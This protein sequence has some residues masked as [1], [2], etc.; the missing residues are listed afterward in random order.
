M[1]GCHQ[2]GENLEGHGHR[3]G[4]C[5][6]CYNVHVILCPTCAMWDWGPLNTD[7]DAVAELIPPAV[8]VPAPRQQQNKLKKFL[9]K[10]SRSTPPCKTFLGRMAKVSK[11]I[12]R[13][14]A[15]K[16]ATLYGQRF[17]EY[18]CH[19]FNQFER[20][21]PTC[22][23]N[24]TAL[25]II[26]F[27]YHSAQE[28]IQC[29]TNRDSASTVRADVE[30][31]KR[32]QI[33]EVAA[34]L[35]LHQSDKIQEVFGR[36]TA[37]ELFNSHLYL[38]ALGYND[39]EFF[40]KGFKSPTLFAID[41]LDFANNS[42]DQAREI[43]EI[44]LIAYHVR[45]GA[46]T[47]NQWGAHW[48]NG[49]AATNFRPNEALSFVSTDHFKKL[50]GDVQQAGDLYDITQQINRVWAVLENENPGNQL[51]D[52]PRFP[53]DN[54]GG[55][56]LLSGVEKNYLQYLPTFDHKQNQPDLRTPC[57]TV[58]RNR[59]VA[60]LHSLIHGQDPPNRPGD[61]RPE[62]APPHGESA[63]P[64][65]K[66]ADD[67]TA[68]QAGQFIDQT[69]TRMWNEFAVDLA[70]DTN[71]A[72]IILQKV[73]NNDPDD[74]FKPKGWFPLKTVNVSWK[75]VFPEDG[76]DQADTFQTIRQ[77]YAAT[78]G[79]SPR[80]AHYM[81]WRNHKDHWLYDCFNIQTTRRP[82]FTSLAVHTILPEP[83]TN[84]GGNVLLFRR[85]TIRHRTVFT[86]G[87]KQQPRRSMLLVLDTILFGR[88]KKDGYDGQAP[89]ERLKVVEKILRRSCFLS[90]TVQAN[91]VN[92][93]PAQWQR[94]CTGIKV[95]YPM[96]DFLI[97]CHIFGGVDMA[98]DVMA[99]AGCFC[100]DPASNDPR[101]AVFSPNLH[102]P[103]S[104]IDEY[105]ND[106]T[107][108]DQH[109]QLLVYDPWISN[110][111]YTMPPNFP[112]PVRPKWWFKIIHS[113]RAE[114]LEDFE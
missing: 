12:K 59:V 71:V 28:R 52:H 46:R 10:F 17:S 53:D 50:F 94:S 29:R 103:R 70:F 38:K 35:L 93:L 96:P 106:I 102:L 108:F 67:W 42:A 77:H 24:K 3:T 22:K 75:D 91:I 11:Y 89:G 13:Q 76:F 80:P 84:Y 113:D 69:I 36:N 65:N 86:F 33:R 31:L 34:E 79:T 39:I 45:V 56:D 109:M 105:R 2:C 1:P 112:A 14:L 78:E 43:L 82:V 64:E 85:N 40:L 81:D 20:L 30:Y 27:M 51:P 54:V 41:L 95:G 100:Y 26:I 15:T 21:Y 47:Q 7:H 104:K 92:N 58:I 62:P 72:K 44:S 48:S 37:E 74:Q 23:Y 114:D 9:A 57:E 19:V 111:I 6:I 98:R 18:A 107:T 5:S 83:N 90:G 60:K 49:G 61:Y 32:W 8:V 63:E 101:K 55:N 66:P 97:E 4:K 68:L 87:D 16:R 99:I 110:P 73:K 25:Q 88:K